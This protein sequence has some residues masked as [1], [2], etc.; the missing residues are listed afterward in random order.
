MTVLAAAQA[1][2]IVLL[3]RKPSSLFSTDQFGLELGQLAT[4]AATAIAEYYDWQKLKKLKTYAG[5]GSTIA[6]DLPTDY[7]RMLKKGEIHSQMWRT[8]N[9]RKARDE[10]EWLLLQDINLAGTPGV[11]ILLGGQMQ[12]F[13]PLPA[14]E[15]ARHYYISNL[16]VGTGDGQPG[17]KTSFIADG[18][19]FV[20]SERLL[21]LAL[22]WRWRSQKRLEYSEDMTNYEIALSE[23]VAKDRGSKVIVVGP[24]RYSTDTTAPYPGQLG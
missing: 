9:F 17:T 13:P 19:N 20:L 8:R 16:I 4:E 1:A 11:W 2:G 24:E 14:A 5:D 21:K 15:T 23:E 22:I 12:F 10:D 18:D 6:F 7:G 3:G